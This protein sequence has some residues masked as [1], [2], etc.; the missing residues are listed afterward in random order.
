MEPELVKSELCFE[1][2]HAAR[3]THRHTH[4]LAHW[5][6]CCAAGRVFALY[7]TQLQQLDFNICFDY[8]ARTINNDTI[9]PDHTHVHTQPKSWTHPM[10]L[11]VSRVLFTLD[12]ATFDLCANIS[13]ISGNFSSQIFSHLSMLL[14]L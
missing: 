14:L 6:T 8:A 2:I 3:S 4:T 5:H 9:I 7:S 11:A 12:F 1:V 13:T 10:R